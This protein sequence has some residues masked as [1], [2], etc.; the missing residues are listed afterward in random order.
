M[1]QDG[2]R[3]KLGRG[4]TECRNLFCQRGPSTNG[5]SW[6]QLRLQLLDV[7]APTLALANV[8]KSSWCRA[9]R[10]AEQCHKRNRTV[11]HP[12]L[13]KMAQP[14]N[15][16]VFLDFSIQGGPAQRVIFELFQ[17]RVPVTAEKYA[18]PALMREVS[19]A[20]KWLA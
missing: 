14:T 3:D 6:G 17:D 20:D 15:P 8:R 9:L 11:G 7:V 1:G 2:R 5:L 4:F 12:G 10:S 19:D 13:G 16:R 18:E